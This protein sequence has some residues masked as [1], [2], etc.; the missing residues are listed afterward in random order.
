MNEKDGAKNCKKFQFLSCSRNNIHI[1]V[2]FPGFEDQ[3]I[4]L[5]TE[6]QE[7]ALVLSEI[8]VYWKEVHTFIFPSDWDIVRK[9]GPRH[10]LI[11]DKIQYCYYDLDESYLVRSRKSH[12]DCHNIER[13]EF[14]LL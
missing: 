4:L 3:V 10:V 12:V 2:T 8:G 9:F 5:S 13:I 7:V 1:H 11:Y 14:K 6:F